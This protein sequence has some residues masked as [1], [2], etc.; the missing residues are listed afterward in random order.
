[1]KGRQDSD[2]KTSAGDTRQLYLAERLIPPAGTRTPCHTAAARFQ[3]DTEER[4]ARTLTVL[5]S[6]IT[7]PNSAH[8]V[9]NSAQ[10]VQNS[11]H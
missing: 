4:S 11:A 9:Q 3:A 6:A 2:S 5:N 1:M 10:T 7:V 8:T